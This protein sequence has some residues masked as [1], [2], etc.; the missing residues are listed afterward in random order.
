MKPQ[1]GFKK[2]KNLAQWCCDPSTGETEAKVLRFQ[3]Q[4]GLHSKTLSQKENGLAEWL[5]W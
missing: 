5:K 1:L 2:K 4:P 3:G